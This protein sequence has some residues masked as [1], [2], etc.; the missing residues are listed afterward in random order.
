MKN[1][2]ITEKQM[3]K[4]IKQQKELIRK[5]GI[6]PTWEIFSKTFGWFQIAKKLSQLDKELY[7]KLWEESY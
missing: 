2:N 4:V 6:E 7:K 3:K 1:Y 5:T